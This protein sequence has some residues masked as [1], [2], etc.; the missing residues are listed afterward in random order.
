[1]ESCGELMGVPA[2][3]PDYRTAMRIY[4]AAMWL[5]DYERYDKKFPYAGGLMEQPYIWKL[6]L[7]CALAARDAAHH[8]KEKEEA[9]QKAAFGGSIGGPS[10]QIPM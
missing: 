8:E 5:Q 9:E 10:S 4:D 7:D 3:D 6:A 1:M 2:G